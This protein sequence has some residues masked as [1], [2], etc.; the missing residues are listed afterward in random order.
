MSSLCQKQNLMLEL[1]VSYEN[2]SLLHSLQAQGN[3][4]LFSETKAYARSNW[5]YLMKMSLCCTLFKLKEISSFFR[6]QTYARI[7][8]RNTKISLCCTLF[9]LKEMSS[10]CQKQN[11]MLELV[12][13]VS[14]VCIL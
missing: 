1:V 6:K 7:G 10:F 5:S 13:V 11:L 12:F 4:F 14:L 8:R 3:I 2:I 9:K